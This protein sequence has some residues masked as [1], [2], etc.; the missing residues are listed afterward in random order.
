MVDPETT[1]TSYSGKGVMNYSPVGHIEKAENPVSVTMTADGRIE[2]KAKGSK[3]AE[4][5]VLESDRNGYSTIK[6]PETYKVEYSKN[7]YFVLIHG[8]STSLHIATVSNSPESFRISFSPQRFH[9][10]QEINHTYDISPI[11]STKYATTKGAKFISMTNRL[12][13]QLE[14]M[15][16]LWSDGTFVVQT[17]HRNPGFGANVRTVH[18]EVLNPEWIA[19]LLKQKT[20][21]EVITHLFNTY[22]REA[23]LILTPPT[24]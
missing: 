24:Q 19:D 9:K 15:T 22:F 5:Y 10:D 23:A 6:N 20:S 7:G 12:G 18:K 8:D 11:D 16:S 21:D 2:M 1:R 3:W 13:T 17:M 14:F 4:H